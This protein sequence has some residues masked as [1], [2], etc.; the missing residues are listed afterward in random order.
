MLVFDGRSSVF[1]DT[2]YANAVEREKEHRKTHG[3]GDNPTP[4]Y[5]A[6]AKQN[7]FKDVLA[8]LQAEG[9]EDTAQK[10]GMEYLMGK[11]FD[12]IFHCAI[13]EG[14]YDAVVQAIASGHNVDYADV[15]GDTALMIAAAW[16]HADI[17]RLFLSIGANRNLRNA[18]GNTAMDLAQQNN[19]Q[20]VINVFNP[21]NKLR[22]RERKL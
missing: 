22:K 4:Q 12:N 10:T 5:I 20:S 15:D 9:I 1:W 19:R 16:G 17:V 11:V 21:F 7:G 13:Q 3:H 14:E 2:A 6:Y 18:K 8:S